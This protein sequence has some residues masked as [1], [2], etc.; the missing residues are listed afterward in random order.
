MK[1]EHKFNHQPHF[2]NLSQ[3]VGLSFRNN[4]QNLCFI[5]T[6]L[7]LL[8]SSVYYRESLLDYICNCELCKLMRIAIKIPLREYDTRSMRDWISSFEKFKH[9]KELDRTGYRYRQ[10]DAQ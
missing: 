3:F 9:L 2:S 10:Q 5:N 7:N 4:G 8:S 6:I 1:A